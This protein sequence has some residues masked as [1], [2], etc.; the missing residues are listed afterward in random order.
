[1]KKLILFL[2]LIFNFTFYAQIKRETRAVWV[3][4]NFHL[5][6]PPHTYDAETQKLALYKIFTNINNKKLNTVYFQI[7]SSGTVMFNSSYEPFSPYLTGETG[8][9]PNYDPLKF[10]ISIAHKKGLEL[11][12]WFNVMRC[13]SG[14]E[15]GI[16]KN[17]NHL[18]NKH[19]EW[20]VKYSKNGKT[21]F[22]LDPG[23]PAVREYLVNLI[24]QVVSNYDVDGIH[25]DFLRYP[26]INFNDD[27]SYNLYGKGEDKSEWRRENITEFLR[28]L[29]NSVRKIKPFVKIGVTPFGIYKNKK[30]AVGTQGYSNVYQDTREWLRLGYIDYAVPQIYWNMDD[31]PRFDVLAK[32][33][34][35]NSFNKNIILGIAA[36]KPEVKSELSKL[37]RFSRSVNAAGV[38]FFRYGSIKNYQFKIFK[39]RV[40]PSTLPRLES[41]KPLPPAN[42]KAIVSSA[43]PNKIELAWDLPNR[44][45][46]TDSVKYYALYKLRNPN[47]SLS[48]INLYD[49]FEADKT[50][51]ALLIYIPRQI[52]YY[53]ALKSVDKLWN[54]SLNSSNVVEVTLPAI[55]GIANQMKIFDKPVL[56]KNIDDTYKLLLFSTKTD[57]I[58]ISAENSSK[59]IILKHSRIL[60]GKNIISLKN[61]F[62]KYSTLI[63]KYLNSGKE[64]K[65]KL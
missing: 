63:I 46:G 51:V 25:L 45:A 14:T 32:D 17:P 36:Y 49:I 58:V 53:F 44:Y 8:K 47:D 35:S 15:K 62:Q 34:L 54:E 43:F 11:H 33:W 37:I 20:V 57:S 31:N 13:F 10:A 7:R 16:L 23:L 24:S 6:W 64:V 42:L 39:N 65:L 28:M 52:K 22:W 9:V 59:Q 60:T 5:D 12:A 1:M 3:A 61:N 29:Y 21:A 18:I 38:A 56:V 19:P 27:Y 55:K 40:F 4:T 41:G 50:S 48:A 26:G 30:R 2:F